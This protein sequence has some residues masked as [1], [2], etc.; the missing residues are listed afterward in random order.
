MDSKQENIKIFNENDYKLE[1]YS[2]FK[3]DKGDID[4]I[5]D[6]NKSKLF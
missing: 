2:S 1:D 3:N 6:N 4:N 5:Y